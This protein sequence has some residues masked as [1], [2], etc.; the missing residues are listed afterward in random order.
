M[1]AAGVGLRG[2][3]FSLDFLL[4]LGISM[5]IVGKIGLPAYHPSAGFEI[6]EWVDTV[7]S[8]AEVAQTQAIA[9][10]SPPPE[11]PTAVLDAISYAINVMFILFWVYFGTCEAFFNGTSMGKR[12]CCIRTVS[13][14]T[15]GAQPIL[16]GI[17]R[18]GI[19]TT[20]IF[21]V[22]PLTAVIALLGLF[23]NKR[24][25]MLHDILSRTTVIDERLVKV[26]E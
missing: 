21:I 22:F 17:I 19:K 16:T 26:N 3:A 18:G 8:W 25:Q 2:L 10:R 4:L 23:F 20:L 5:L 15:L 24:K 7:W 13:T 1:P 14:V 6:R 12:L 9:E 11:M